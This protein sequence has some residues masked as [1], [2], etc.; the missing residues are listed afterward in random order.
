ME[1]FNELR[2]KAREKRDKAIYAIKDAYETTLVRIAALEQDILG[3]D[4]SGHKSIAECINSVLPSDREFTT[5]DVMASLEAM[6][7]RRVWQRHSIDSHI[8]R[9]RERGIV[10]RLTKAKGPQPAVYVRVGVDHQPAPFEDMRLVDVAAQVLQGRSLNI[11]ELAVSMLEQGYRTTMTQ[12][13]LRNALAVAMKKN[14]G[15]FAERSGKW[16]VAK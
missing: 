12:R 5:V 14:R 7:S 9:L 6:N 16:S 3:K 2:R 15:W 13:G 1:A 8:S 10:K 4:L 11:T